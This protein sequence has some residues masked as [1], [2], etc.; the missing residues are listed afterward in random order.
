MR[1]V[2]RAALLA[3]LIAHGRSISTQSVAG[4][5]SKPGALNHAAALDRLRAD[6]GG[7][8]PLAIGSIIDSQQK[9]LATDGATGDQFGTSVA[10]SGDTLVIGASADDIGA[11]QNQGSVYVYTRGDGGWVE[12]QILTA[13]DGEAQDYFGSS[14]ALVGDFLVVGAYGDDIGG[15]VNQGSAYVF[16]RYGGVWTQRQKLVAA[17][18]APG[19]LFGYSV[20]ISGDT[21]AVGS[22][23]D[24]G[25]NYEQGA[26][27]V[28]RHGHWGWT[29]QQQITASDGAP[30]D[31]FGAAVALDG[32][33]LLV[34]A[35][36]DDSGANLNQG[37]AYVFTRSDVVWTEQQKLVASDGAAEDWFGRAVAISG[38]TL[39]VGAYL[40]DV[41]ANANQGAAYVF[42][43]GGGVWTERQQLAAADGAADDNFGGSIALS[44]E[45]M[46]VGARMDDL[47][48]GTDQGSAYVF[49]R[50]GGGDWAQQEKLTAGDAATRDY[51]GYSVAVDGE[52]LAVGAAGDDVSA[53]V[54][55]GSAYLFTVPSCPALIFTPASLPGGVS[56]VSYQRQITVSGGVGPY[57]FALVSGAAPPGLSL[58]TDG[59]LSG[60]PTT[61]GSYLFKVRATDLNTQCSTVKKYNL[62]IAASCP[63]ILIDPASLPGG[64]VGARYRQALTAT[65][66][67]EPYTFGVK[68][69]L[70]PGLSLS[71]G[72]L[73]GAP[74]Q[75]GYYSF[76][77]LVADGNGCED[78]GAYSLTIAPANS[79]II[80]QPAADSG[81]RQIITSQP[82]VPREK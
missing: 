38:D 44:G 48:G 21:L 1:I 5:E 27:Y 66:G 78:I 65:G 33:T 70:P 40:K 6:N 62:T 45:T 7:A 55:Q 42:T 39:V 71:G 26:V 67:A 51:F 10:L 75:S 81:A 19:D 9:L 59:S 72:M 35:S 8:Y 36:M 57:Q 34:G 46:S 50:N 79:G 52:T 13:S 47:N 32:D 2:A 54:N 58:M 61:P 64:R 20:A 11:N 73:G 25:T 80:V 74:T 22:F 53:N 43:R 63:P 17:G 30:G 37:S 49:M 3:L 29:L 77:L 31:I 23:A 76:W 24:N 14:V 68:G 28:Y 15:N 18:G 82:A 56:G 12:Q 4:Q 60:A 41:G 69:K 16:M